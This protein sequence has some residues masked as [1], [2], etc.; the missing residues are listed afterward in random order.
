[1]YKKIHFYK[2]NIYTPLIIAKEGY[3]HFY[4]LSLIPYFANELYKGES[5]K[6]Y[7]C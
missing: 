6:N 5:A 3:I 4:K 1:M 7:F 2:N